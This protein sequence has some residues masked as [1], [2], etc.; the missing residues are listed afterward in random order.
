MC[1]TVETVEPLPHMFEGTRPMLSECLRHQ[2][3]AYVYP[4]L[5]R[6]TEDYL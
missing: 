6:Y 4:T 2:L 5:H 1:E 3:V